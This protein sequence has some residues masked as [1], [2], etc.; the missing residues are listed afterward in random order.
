MA[1]TQREMEERF[2]EE[3]AGIWQEGFDSALESVEQDKAEA[4]NA[5]A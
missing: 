2:G 3:K 1:E 5:A 4:L